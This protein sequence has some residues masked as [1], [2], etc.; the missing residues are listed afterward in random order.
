MAGQKLGPKTGLRHPDFVVFSGPKCPGAA[1][2]VPV[3]DVQASVVKLIAIIE[4][5]RLRMMLQLNT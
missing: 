3:V 1:P 2:L 5:E 4:L